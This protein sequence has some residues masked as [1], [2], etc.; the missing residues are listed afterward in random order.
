MMNVDI[1]VRKLTAKELPTYKPQLVDW[2]CDAYA[3][4][5]PALVFGV[6]EGEN[7]YQALLN[8]LKNDQG[9]VLGLFKQDDLLGFLWYFKTPTNRIHVNEI[10]ISPEH[11]SAGYGKVLFQHLFT[12]GKSE[13]VNQ[14]ELFVTC[15]NQVAV[16]FYEK[17][18]FKPER[19]LMVKDLVEER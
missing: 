13:G 10:I 14:V 3:L 18:D 4:N 7:R 9:Q 16:S 15:S 6:T 12:V 8:Y 17:Y 11:R 2:F 1:S 5:F 19:M